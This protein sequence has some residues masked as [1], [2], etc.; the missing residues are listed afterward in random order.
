MQRTK[1]GLCCQNIWAEFHFNSKTAICTHKR[2]YVQGTTFYM[3]RIKFIPSRFL[4]HGATDFDK[5]CSAYTHPPI[6][7]CAPLCYPPCLSVCL[8]VCLSTCLLN[9]FVGKNYL[10]ET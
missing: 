3:Q 4:K 2:N 9:M 6:P 1:L 5:A 7:G 10:D 8:F